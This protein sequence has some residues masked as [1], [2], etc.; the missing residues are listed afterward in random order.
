MQRAPPVILPAP[1][2][3]WRAEPCRPLVPLR[4][5]S[6]ELTLQPFQA[7]DSTRRQPPRLGVLSRR[8]RLLPEHDVA[9]LRRHPRGEFQFADKDFSVGAGWLGPHQL[10]E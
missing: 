10:L 2:Q 7:T 5:I 4:P 3:K 1:S 6:V 8:Q 9:R